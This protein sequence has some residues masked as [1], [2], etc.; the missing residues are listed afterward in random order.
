M[1]IPDPDGLSAALGALFA[2]VLFIGG[3]AALFVGF[4]KIIGVK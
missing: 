1:T 4:S 2:Y 3:M